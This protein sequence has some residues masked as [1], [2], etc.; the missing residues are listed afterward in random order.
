VFE[1]EAPQS[2]VS[3]EDFAV[4]VVDEAERGEHPLSC[5]AVASR[6]P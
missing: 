3:T 2:L 1:G 6:R 4:A 5:I